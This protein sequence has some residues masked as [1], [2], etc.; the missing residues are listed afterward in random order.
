MST[1]STRHR[2]NQK[3][4]SNLLDHDLIEQRALQIARDEGRD[5]IS[6]ED[7][8]RAREE[9][10]APNEVTGEPEISPEMHPQITAWDEAP[11]S[12]GK[13]VDKVTP[14]DEASIGKELVEKGMRGPRRTRSGED[15]LRRSQ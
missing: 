9:L 6:Q 8:A 3:A 7:R 13:K 14:E 4:E 2:R 1:K 12:T 10:L 15:P 5:L 11:A